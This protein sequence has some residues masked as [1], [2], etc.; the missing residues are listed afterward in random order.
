MRDI[1]IFELLR[2]ID[3]RLS[4]FAADTKGVDLPTQQLI[5]PENNPIENSILQK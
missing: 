4:S 5:K 1:V 2:A 3:L